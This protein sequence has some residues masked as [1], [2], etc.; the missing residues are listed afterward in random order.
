MLSEVAPSPVVTLNQAVAVAMVH[1]PT[2]G[3]DMLGPLQR[4]QQMRRHHRLYA[5]RAHLLEM[6]G[7]VEEARA[8]FAIA[9]RLATSIP[10]Q[11][12]LNSKAAPREV[13]ESSSLFAHGN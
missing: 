7:Q 6:D 10:E 3:L 2:A 8:L 9:A 4:N 13:Q 11:R 5:V 1:G 12:Y